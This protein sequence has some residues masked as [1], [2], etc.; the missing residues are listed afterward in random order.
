MGS[1]H[2]AKSSV[3][4]KISHFFNDIDDNL[5][6]DKIYTH[7]LN[8]FKLYVKNEII[9]KYPYDCEIRDCYNCTRT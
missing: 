4:F 8:G 7:S 2:G 6:K 5:I 3:Q 9:D 1:I